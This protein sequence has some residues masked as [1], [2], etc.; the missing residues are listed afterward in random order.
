MLSKAQE[1]GW[2]V[3]RA[4]MF[5]ECPR[6]YYY[7]YYFSKVGY[8]PDAPDDARLALEM[9]DIKGLDMWVGE[10]VHETIQWLLEQTHAGISISKQDAN[11]KIRQML[12]DGWRSS[13]KQLWRRNPKDNLNLFEHYYGIEV[14]M[15]TI[16]RLK[17]K[18]FLSINNFI[19]SGVFKRIQQTPVTN[20]LPVEKYASFRADGIL[21]YVKFDFAMKD[22]N[23]LLV[24]DW[25][26]G[27]PDKDIR[28]QLT[29]YAMYTSQ[30]WGVGVGDIGVYAAFLQPE[31]DIQKYNINDGDMEEARTFIKHSFGEISKCLSHPGRNIAAMQNYPLTGN[32]LRCSRCNFKGMCEQG[33]QIAEGAYDSSDYQD[34]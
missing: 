21:V 18:A 6:R 29:C 27:R 24:Y 7:H 14:G 30:K 31:L 13:V 17:N 34:C 20:W 3:S 12:S 28:K 23:G 2:S 19:D 5:E 9:K 15:A 1:P 11:V 32:L 33:R 16:D 22:G 4:R 25:K 26:T 10:A 8:A